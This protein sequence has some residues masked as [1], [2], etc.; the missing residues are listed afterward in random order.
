MI[1]VEKRQVRVVFDEREHE[2]LNRTL[3]VDRISTADEIEVDWIP[4]PL[5]PGE[6]RVAVDG[7]AMTFEGLRAVTPNY[8]PPAHETSGE[9]TTPQPLGFFFTARGAGTASIKIEL[10][11]A[12]VTSLELRINVAR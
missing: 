12:K 5:P 1:G 11:S 4:W 8:S 3:V 7:S 2:P 6:W 9:A 10:K